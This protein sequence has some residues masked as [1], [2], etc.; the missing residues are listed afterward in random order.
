LGVKYFFVGPTGY[1]Y[2]N[3]YKNKDALRLNK[4]DIKKLKDS[5]VKVQKKYKHD[6]IVALST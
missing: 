1:F 5:L 6:M 2:G 4:N 3:A